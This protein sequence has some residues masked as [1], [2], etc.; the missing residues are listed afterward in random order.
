MP[1]VVSIGWELEYAL[2]RNDMKQKELAILTKTPNAT[3][4]DHVQG[5]GVRVEKAVE[6]SEAINDNIFISQMS[7]DTF[8]FVKSADGQLTDVMTPFELN[9]F[10]DIETAER[11]KRRDKAKELLLKSKLEKLADAD[12]NELEEYVLQFL[13]EIVVELSI[14]FSILDILD[15][16]ITETFDKRMPVW[17]D[18]KYMKG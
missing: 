13:D 12:E 18:K 10:E 17:I 16:S 3:V 6:Y 4:S 11:E 14:V 15:M 9:F 8:G 1:K 5:G 7:Y 2:E